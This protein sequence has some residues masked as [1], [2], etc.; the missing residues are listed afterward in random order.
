[1]AIRIGIC[2]SI[3]VGE[4]SNA[5]ADVCCMLNEGEKL[6]RRKSRKRGI[7]L[8]SVFKQGVGAS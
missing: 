5:I 6:S 4:K 8:Q 2:A 7:V 3:L 1:M